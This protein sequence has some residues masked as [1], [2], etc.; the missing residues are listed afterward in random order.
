MSDPPRNQGREDDC[1]E[2]APGIRVGRPRVTV[3]QEG[4]K[5]PHATRGEPRWRRSFVPLLLAVIVL[6]I[7]GVT[8]WPMR[9]VPENAIRHPDDPSA[10]LNYE[11]LSTLS[12]LMDHVGF[13]SVVWLGRANLGGAPSPDPASV[14]RT[15]LYRSGDD[16]GF[17]DLSEGPFVDAF[18]DRLVAVFHNI[19]SVFGGHRVT[20]ATGRQPAVRFFQHQ[21]EVG[22]FIPGIGLDVDF[23]TFSTDERERLTRVMFETAVPELDVFADSLVGTDIG[24]VGYAIQYGTRD[25]TNDI[26][27]LSLPETVMLVAHLSD[28]AEYA[29]LAI[30]DAELV[31]RSMVFFGS[32]SGLRRVDPNQ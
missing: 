13:A 27:D 17:V 2:V 28:V 26:I 18:A 22:V 11:D 16:L 20:L 30:T 24:W 21:G 6:A 3:R 15:V 31:E 12:D 5:P 32:G 8:L 10:F 9:G 1:E 23:N 19:G 29:D 25:F 4:A 14:D 7:A